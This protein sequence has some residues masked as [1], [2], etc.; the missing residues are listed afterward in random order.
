MKKFELSYFNLL[1]K[2]DYDKNFNNNIP[3]IKEIIS[4]IK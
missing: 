2:I 4:G 1:I 3:E